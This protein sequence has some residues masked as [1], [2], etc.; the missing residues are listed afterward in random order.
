M[1]NFVTI[2][3]KIQ[4]KWTNFLKDITI[5]APSKRNNMNS[6]KSIKEI[7]F[8]DKSLLINMSPG[9]DAFIPTKQLRKNNTKCTTKFQENRKRKE[10][11]PTHSMGAALP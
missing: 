4:R 5:K 9:S 6:N 2:N 3:L 1:N 8:V 11:F 7:K 10:Y